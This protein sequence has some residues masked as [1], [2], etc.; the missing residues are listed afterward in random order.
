MENNPLTSDPVLLLGFT[1]AHAA[2]SIAEAEA[3]ELLCPLAF[4]ER[5][6][7]LEL[8]R[9]E[10]N[11]QEDAISKGRDYINLYKENAVAS[12]FAREGL[13]PEQNKKVDALLVECWAKNDTDHYGIIQKFIPNE[14]KGKFR[15]LGE[16]IILIDGVIQTEETASVLKGKL[17]RGIQAHSKVAQLW[18]QWK[19]E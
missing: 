13:F 7:N 14:G 10:S 15:L 9:F 4:L 1:L 6:G 8:V 5:H 19:D 12:S 18:S 11:T 17:E 16:P 2:W 3:E